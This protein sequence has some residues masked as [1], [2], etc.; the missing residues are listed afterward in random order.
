MVAINDEET[1]GKEIQI[2]WAIR[3]FPSSHRIGRK[4]QMVLACSWELGSELKKILYV[5]TFQT[6][7][8]V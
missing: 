5:R 6:R 3:L 7:P 1:V 2:G 4:R 8:N